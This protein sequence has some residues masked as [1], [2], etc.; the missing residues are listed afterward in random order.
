MSEASHK[1]VTHTLRVDLVVRLA[2]IAYREHVSR[3][4][5]IEHA[6]DTLFGMHPK[7]KTLGEA[8]RD[9]GAGLRRPRSG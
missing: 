2:R 8:L 6:V 3:S 1:T 5:I 9:N 7:D 4:A